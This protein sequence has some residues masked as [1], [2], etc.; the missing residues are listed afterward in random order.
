MKSMILALS[1]QQQPRTKRKRSRQT[2]KFHRKAQ[3]VS[4]YKLVPERV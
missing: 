2:D 3:V 1:V 4:T